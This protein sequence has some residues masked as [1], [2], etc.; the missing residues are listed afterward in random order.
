[1]FLLERMEK[2]IQDHLF[3]AASKFK[4]K[5]L[6]TQQPVELFALGGLGSQKFMG[7]EAEPRTGDLLMVSPSV[8]PEEVL[9]LEAVRSC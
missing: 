2:Q 5:Q 1:M 3:T 9:A 6:L 7:G 4:R 8:E